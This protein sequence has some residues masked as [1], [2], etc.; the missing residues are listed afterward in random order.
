MKQAAR[1]IAIDIL[2]AWE[3][4]KESFDVVMN[5]VSPQ[6]TLSD[7]RDRQLIMALIYGVIRWR[8]FLDEIIILFAK[9]PLRKMKI[10][11]LT[12]LRVGLY[13]IIFM[14]RIPDAA[15]V[16]EVVS[17]LKAA[18]QPRWL[19]GFV[20]GVLRTIVNNK[21]KL[22][23]PFSDQ[24][25]LKSHPS[26]LVDLWNKRYGGEKT[27]EICQA[28]NHLPQLCLRVNVAKI[29]LDDFID[30][31]RQDGLKAAMANFAPD[32]VRLTDY[33]GS[34]VSLP[35]YEQ[36]FFQVQDEA[37]QL[38][39]LLMKPEAASVYLDGCAGLGGKSCHLA[40][41]L[42]PDSRIIAVEPNAARI[43]LLR[44][45]LRRLGVVSVVEVYEG[46]LLD[47]KKET[48]K[49]FKSILI[50]APCSGLGVIRRRPDIRW[51]RSFKDLLRYQTKQLSLL[52]TAASMLASGGAL[53]YVTCS[54]ASE[55]NEEVV[56]LFLDNHSE[57]I[58]ENTG[59]FLPAK[60]KVFVDG[61]G[62]FRTL[63]DKNDL[64]GFFAA[65][66]LKT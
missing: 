33:K 6:Y 4:T 51:N 62:F 2:S 30:L 49:I 50:D 21:E 34:I 45:N 13:Q 41:L 22:P 65:R 40:G 5:R 7:N 23:D 48:K 29:Q 18:G 32:A 25:M 63:P 1:Y 17:A 61:Q 44:E 16:N 43:K 27:L 19:T 8:N 54:T 15:A 28:N 3:Q 59:D 14:D 31:L 9:H 57:F 42:P 11:T 64:D 55:E 10:R 26:W 60:A 35:G 37:A 24:A 38:V 46:T 58:K 56:S 36:G 66:L 12:A 52:D 20:N 39:T 47:F 53:V